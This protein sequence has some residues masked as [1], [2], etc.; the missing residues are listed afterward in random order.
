M[1]KGRLTFQEDLFSPKTVRFFNFS[2]KS[3]CPSLWGRFGPAWR[4]KGCRGMVWGFFIFLVRGGALSACLVPSLCGDWRLH[5]WLPGV[6]G[7]LS[8][9]QPTTQPQN[10]ILI[11]HMK[12][13][14]S[15]T[16]RIG[17]Q[18]GRGRINIQIVSYRLYNLANLN[19]IYFKSN[20]W[21]EEN[22]P[23]NQINSSTRA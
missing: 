5:P 17:G 20:I 18:W 6:P 15:E 16:H 10:C 21:I 4:G 3:F 12:E 2:I 11:L 8:G 1:P 19:S 9:A 13:I 23:L 7:Q 14:A 22:S